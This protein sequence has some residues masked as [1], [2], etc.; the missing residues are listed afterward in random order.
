MKAPLTSILAAA[1]LLAALPALAQT[2]HEA[3]HRGQ[4]ADEGRTVYTP[5][6][7]CVALCNMDTSPCDPPEFKHADGRCDYPMIGR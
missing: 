5:Q 4:R 6:R 3:R 1:A 2:P 7:V